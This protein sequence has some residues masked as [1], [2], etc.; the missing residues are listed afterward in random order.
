MHS[1]SHNAGSLWTQFITFSGVKSSFFIAFFSL[2]YVMI[3]TNNKIRNE[4]PAS[5]GSLTGLKRVFV[6]SISPARAG[7]NEPAASLGRVQ[8]WID[9]YGRSTSARH[10]DRSTVERAGARQKKQNGRLLPANR[11]PTNKTNTQGLNFTFHLLT[12][13]KS[14]IF[15]I[16]YIYNCIL[17]TFSAIL[18]N[19]NNNNN[20]HAM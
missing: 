12:S 20:N 14:N 1:V 13:N 5:T 11:L 15:H 8:Q 9:P 3:S 16:V 2:N 17:I 10:V 7:T 18:I 4:N 6:H 19:N